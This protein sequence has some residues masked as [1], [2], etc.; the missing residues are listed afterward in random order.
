MKKEKDDRYMTVKEVADLWRCG[1]GA[2]Y[3][4]VNRGD[5]HRVPVKVR[6]T[7]LYRDEVMNCMPNP[8]ET[9]PCDSERVKQLEAELAKYKTYLANIQTVVNGAVN[10]AH[11]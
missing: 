9:A 6:K 3:S 2:V 7:L 11:G 4:A 8:E 10:A 5:L 1:V